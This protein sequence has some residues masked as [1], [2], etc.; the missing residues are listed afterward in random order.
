MAQ[1]TAS[2]PL[3]GFLKL[4]AHEV[5]WQLLTALTESDL[6]VQ[7]LVE[8]LKRPQNLISYHLRLLRDGQVVN[9]HRSQADGRDVYYSL[10][11]E[12]LRMLYLSSGQALHPG[13][14]TNDPPT[15]AEAESPTTNRQPVR[16]LFLCT[17]NSARSQLAEGIMRQT[18]DFPVAVF[19]AG[20]EPGTVH[21]LAIRAAQHLGL[22]ISGQR[23]KHLDEF[24]GQTFAYVITVCD[25]VRELCPVFTPEPHQIHWSFADPSAVV[26]TEEEQFQAFLQTAR[27]LTTRINYLRLMI[28]RRQAYEES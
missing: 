27:E 12:H 3:P 21:P 17:H 28:N 18:S 19:S 10:E 15:H 5:R 22:D 4:L 23:S 1:D 11:L 8:R 2:P 26:G 9:E 13:L 7:E 24:S 16:I 20:N 25:R 14:T 6:R